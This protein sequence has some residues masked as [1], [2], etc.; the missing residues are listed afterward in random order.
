MHTCIAFQAVFSHSCIL[1]NNYLEE[2]VEFDVEI[3]VID[4]VLRQMGE[5]GIHG[6]LQQSP[7]TFFFNHLLIQLSFSLPSISIGSVHFAAASASK[8][9]L[10]RTSSSFTGLVSL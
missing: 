3:I 7:G 4:D 9:P 5:K 1:I 8:Q 2:I 6:I 10:F